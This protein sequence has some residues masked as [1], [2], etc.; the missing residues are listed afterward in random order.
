M[1]TRQSI[2]FLTSDDG[3]RIAC[4]ESGSG[5]PL[6]KVANW[7]SHVFAKLEVENRGQAIVRARKAG[8]GGS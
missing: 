2:R 6:I 8:F 7:L 5:P 1:R 4:A 3:T